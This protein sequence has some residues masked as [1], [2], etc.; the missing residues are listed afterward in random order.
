MVGK[1]IVNQGEVVPFVAD[2]ECSADREVIVREEDP[3]PPWALPLILATLVSGVSASCAQPAEKR[4]DDSVLYAAEAGQEF[5]LDELATLC[6]QP[7]ALH[8][9]KAAAAK[10]F[11]AL[12]GNTAPIH[13]MYGYDL[14]GGAAVSVSVR[15]SPDNDDVLVLRSVGQRPGELK[16]LEQSTTCEQLKGRQRSGT[17]A[18]SSSGE[19]ASRVVHAHAGATAEQ[20]DA[21][22]E[23][24]LDA[25]GNVVV[26]TV[27]MNRGEFV[28]ASQL[29]AS[30]RWTCGRAPN[31]ARAGR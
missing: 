26:G 14:P 20:R 3:Y 18:A 25:S 9:L 6:R 19:T 17:N 31:G 8:S 2:R 30:V 16:Q 23:G 28:R 10:D 13:K 5:G 24:R 29:I 11:V 27:V 15:V 1:I 12:P 22:D 7:E 21:A 4:R